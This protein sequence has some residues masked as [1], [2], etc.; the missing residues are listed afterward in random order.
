MYSDIPTSVSNILYIDPSGASEGAEVPR[1]TWLGG[2]IHSSSSF[3]L[4]IPSVDDS[5]MR[6]LFGDRPS[7]LSPKSN[8]RVG[9][10]MNAKDKIL[11][12]PN[13]TVLV[14]ELSLK[15]SSQTYAER[16]SKHKNPAARL[17]LETMERKKSNLA[18]SVDLTR[19]ADFL[20]VIDTVGPYACLIKARIRPPL[21]NMEWFA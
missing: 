11:Y 15:M 19:T 6:A 5:S 3:S 18:V 7:S 1:R 8:F 14:L 10:S 4:T 20:S 17:L 9:G 16:T 2:K 21:Y 12:S 13:V